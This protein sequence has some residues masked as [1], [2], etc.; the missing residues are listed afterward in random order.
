MPEKSLE[1]RVKERPTD[2][3]LALIAVETE[4]L[5]QKYLILAKSLDMGLTAVQNEI[6]TLEKDTH[7]A[8]VELW[9]KVNENE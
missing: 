3:A 7:E 4:K 6:A 1:E 5:E 2:A 9:K 8:L